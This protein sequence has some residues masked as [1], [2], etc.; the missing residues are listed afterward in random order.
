CGQ[1]RRSETRWSAG[2]HRSIAT[3]GARASRH[4]PF[5]SRSAGG[6]QGFV[7]NHHQSHGFPEVSRGKKPA[8]V[9]AGAEMRLQIVQYGSP[10]LRAK[11][12]RVEEVDDRIRQLAADMIETM[13]AANG[14]GLAAQQIGEALQLAV[15]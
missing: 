14:V 13:R 1:E 7:R 10:V 6:S 5:V 4:P 9:H 11:G 8:G 2:C 12:R 15:V 3:G